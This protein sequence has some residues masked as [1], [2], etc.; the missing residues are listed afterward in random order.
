[1][2]RNPFDEMRLWVIVCSR[3]GTEYG[4]QSVRMVC[5]DHR[6][7]NSYPCG[8][9]IVLRPVDECDPKAAS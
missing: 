9:L 4:P 2:I 6:P 1:V 7:A 5:M 8:G 3:C